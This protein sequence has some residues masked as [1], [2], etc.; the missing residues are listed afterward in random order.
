MQNPVNI[1][2]EV[3]NEGLTGITDCVM[4]ITTITK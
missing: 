1:P 2:T 4:P 3:I